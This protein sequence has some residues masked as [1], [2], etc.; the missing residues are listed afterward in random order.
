LSFM[1]SGHGQQTSAIFNASCGSGDQIIFNIVLTPNFIFST[2]G[3]VT[4]SWEAY[5]NREGN[6]EVILI[7]HEWFSNLLVSAFSLPA[8]FRLLNQ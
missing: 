6:R 7:N 1:Q 5:K 3:G 8:R 2:C 4:F